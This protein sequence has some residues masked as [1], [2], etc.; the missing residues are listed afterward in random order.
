MNGPGQTLAIIVVGLLGSVRLAAQETP[1]YVID[2]RPTRRVAAEL[3]YIVTL[4][5]ARVQEWVFFAPQLAL[6]PAQRGLSTR[7]TPAG[8]PFMTLDD[9][10]QPALRGRL[11]MKT[12]AEPS[13]LS[14]TVQY[15]AELFSRRLV[16]RDLRRSYAEVPA[17][18][19]AQ[20][21]AALAATRLCEHASPDF[22]R[23]VEQNGLRRR[24]AEDEIAY[25]RRVFRFVR[26]GF[27]YDLKPTMDRRLTSVCRAQQSD[28]GG[29]SLLF[30]GVLRSE[31]IPAR[32]LVG[33][34]AKSSEPGQR[35]GEVDYDQQH[36]KAEFFA[37]GVGWTPVD[38]AQAVAYDRTP[39]GMLYF[40][41]DRGDFLVMHLDY[42]LT[43]DTVHFGEQSVA[44]VQ[45]VPWWARGGGNFNNMQVSQKWTVVDQE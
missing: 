37:A 17:L 19:E 24:E 20:R 1:R 27:R 22:K 8:E 36:V 5:E 43:F 3:E 26:D 23:W 33:R 7:M 28:C 41:A 42:D 12:P 11:A 34:W 45:N 15:E 16:P 38:C 44:W 2:A 29:L 10:P 13:K 4:P 14:V 9:F 18:D 39:A 35:I 25:A 21:E 31:G 6:H 30:T 40:G 32:L